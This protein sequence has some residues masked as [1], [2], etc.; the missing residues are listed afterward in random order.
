MKTFHL[1]VL[2]FLVALSGTVSPAAAQLEWR[3]SVK[4]IL[5]DGGN[6][7]AADGALSSDAE[8]QAQITTGNQILDAAGR[9][10][11]LR[12]TEIV[13]LSGVDEWFDVD[14]VENKGGLEGAA[15]ADPA[16]YAW[17]TNAINI[18]INGHSSSGV[19]SFPTILGED[20][21][22]LGQGVRD[23][24]ILHEIGHFM[25][26]CHTQGCICGSCDPGAF[27]D[28]CNRTPGNDEVA[29]TLPDLECWN[30]DDIAQWTFSMN[31]SALPVGLQALVD[32]VFFN[33]MSYH[34]TRDR[35]TNDQMDRAT[36]ASNDARVSVTNGRTRFVDLDGNALL[37]FGS[38]G[39]P[40]VSVTGGVTD[41]SGGDIVLV[42]AGTYNETLTI[43][44]PV[45]LRASRGVVRI[46][47]NP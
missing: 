1:S 37:Q 24:T 15:E 13:D 10:Y 23:T 22:F 38:A 27:L 46:G 25:N 32:D 31:Y 41:A 2:T 18:Y 30:R 45:T 39:L 3:V 14:V 12:L 19:C 9:G 35:L 21:I 20:I 43:T 34:G 4:F 29:D 8:V 42:R 33:V 17:R 6:R 7:P 5:D 16:T 26:L 40:F 28:E 36:D 11:R 44:K 47:V